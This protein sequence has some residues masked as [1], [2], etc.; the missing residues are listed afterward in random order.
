MYKKHGSIKL[1]RKMFIKKMEEFSAFY[2]INP[3]TIG[4]GTYGEV[5]Q[6]RHKITKEIRAVKLIRK[7][8]MRNIDNFLK[9]VECLKM[10]VI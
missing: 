10:L 7:P 4:K 2:D 1:D 9:E 3:K 8:N 6:C 5:Y